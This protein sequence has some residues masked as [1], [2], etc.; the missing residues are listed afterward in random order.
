MKAK[1]VLILVVAALM[2]VSGLAQAA[3]SSGRAA[4]NA[5]PGG[6][7]SATRSAAKSSSR[8]STSRPTQA[9]ASTSRPTQARASTSRPTQARASTSRPTQARASTSRPTQARPTVS[10]TPRVSSNTARTSRSTVTRSAPTRSAATVRGT[11]ASHDRSASSRPSVVRRT[12]VVRT[13]RSVAQADRRAVTNRVSTRNGVRTTRNASVIRHDR[14]TSPRVARQGRPATSRSAGTSVPRSSSRIVRHDRPTLRQYRL[15]REGV[16]PRIYHQRPRVVQHRVYDYYRPRAIHRYYDRPR[17]FHDYGYYPY[18]G[19]RH[20]YYHRPRVHFYGVG[21]WPWSSVSFGLG[22]YSYPYYWAGAGLYDPYPRVIVNTTT[23]YAYEPY[24]PSAAVP[25]QVSEQD[26][27]IGQVLR[28]QDDQ[29]IEAA[30]Q[31]RQFKDLRTVAVL[32]DVLINDGNAQVRATAAESLGEIAD[33]AAYEALVRS[34]ASDSDE[35]RPSAEQALNR[36]QAQVDND[37]LR[38][39]PR[40]PPMNQGEEDLALYLEDLRYGDADARKKAAEKLRDFQGTQSVAGLINALM[41]DPYAH[42]RENAAE[43]LGKIGDRMAL[44]FL[45]YVQYTDSDKDVRKDA[46]KSIEKIYNA[47]Q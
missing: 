28:D 37:Q 44:P 3:R 25:L 9:R 40:M 42:V 6:N 7:G 18:Y 22:Y 45:K 34:A 17:L 8:A 38:L 16:R 46:E 4:R 33:P 31:L 36:L 30:R 13:T 21:Y 29:R 12:P 11:P 27:L 20:H 47:I 26:Q 35:V 23:N 15:G 10:R 14:A 43:S 1:R 41:N 19:W 2:L 39:S 24:G 32:V 5:R